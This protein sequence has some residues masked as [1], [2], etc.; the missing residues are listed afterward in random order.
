M[1]TPSGV[2]KKNFPKK[3]GLPK[4]LRW[5]THFAQTKISANT[6]GGTCS[7]VCP[8]AHAQFSAQ[9]PI[10]TSGNCPAHM[11]GGAIFF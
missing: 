2:L 3:S 11:L 10:E 9:P 6:D 1:T 5:L 4:L 8:S 7:R